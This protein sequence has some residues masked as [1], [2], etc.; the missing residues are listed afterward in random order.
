M[1][2]FMITAGGIHRVE[3]R[4][5]LVA[6]GESVRILDDLST[7]RSQNLEGIADKVELVRGDLRDPEVVAK[8]VRASRSSCTRRR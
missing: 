6:R 1:A 7:G 8:A 5:A 3:P 2:R 4:H